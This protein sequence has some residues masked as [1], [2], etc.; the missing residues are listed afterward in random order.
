MNTSTQILLKILSASCL[1]LGTMVACTAQTSGD[2]FAAIEAGDAAKVEKILEAQPQLASEPD[3]LGFTPLTQAAGA[4]ALWK[5]IM[6]RN[7][8]VNTSQL[9]HITI[10]QAAILNHDVELLEVLIAKGCRV[11]DQNMAGENAMHWLTHVSEPDL[12]KKI[13]AMIYAKAPEL[14][15]QAGTYALEGSTIENRTPLWNTVDRINPVVAELLMKHGADPNKQP[16]GP[17]SSAKEYL[18]KRLAEDNEWRAKLQ[19]VA[20][21]MGV[22]N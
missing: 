17:G 14:V 13:F 11:S 12:A 7:P 1:L 3:E 18:L 5:P 6:A 4:P 15:D 20:Q 9:C 10:L 8:A 19:P 22:S 2:L 21:A 16:E